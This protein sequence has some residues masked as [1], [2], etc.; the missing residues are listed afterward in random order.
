MNEQDGL[1]A[2]GIGVSID[3]TVI[4]EGVH[5]SVQPGRLTVLIGPNGAGKST[6]I[7]VLAGVTRP[8]SGSL[9][10]NGADWLAQPR[11]RRAR[12][13]ALVEQDARAELPM[14]VET[15]VGLGRTPYRSLLA[16]ASRDDDA[17][18]RAAMETIGIE[19]FAGR[20]FETLSGGER[21]R[22][23][24]ARA[25][26][27]QPEL[28]LLDEPTNHLDVH[29]QLA[30]LELVAALSHEQG[31]AA[32][33]VLH[34]LN[35]AAAYADDLIVLHAGRVVAAGPPHL[36]LTSE[37]LLTV[38]GVEASILQH[39]VTG[40]PLIAYSPLGRAGDR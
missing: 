16:A 11:R 24:L 15:V 3:G 28:L 2:S 36:V 20:S 9:S 6:L 17:V 22:V 26:A 10:W 13:A 7:R 8:N 30:S 1:R 25:L 35:L 12:I 21:Q 40:R 23:H 32:F 31:V 34:D 29:A 4:V 19:H 14:S 39:P 5:C 38:Y 33:A 27:Q 37:M 18:V